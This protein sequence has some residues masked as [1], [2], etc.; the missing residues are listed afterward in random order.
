M[1]GKSRQLQ[2][3]RLHVP[4]CFINSFS[5]GRPLYPHSFVWGKMAA[6]IAVG[7]ATRFQSQYLFDAGVVIMAVVV[8]SATRFQPQHSS[9]AGGRCCIE[10]NH[11]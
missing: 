9:D 11:E 7:S 5:T 4:R 1:R 6:L 8:G 2:Y 3:I 10:R